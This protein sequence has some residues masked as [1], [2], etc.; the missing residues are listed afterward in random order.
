LPYLFLIIFL[1]DLVLLAVVQSL[2]GLLFIILLFPLT[3]SVYASLCFKGFRFSANE[4]IKQLAGKLYWIG[5][6]TIQATLIA[7]FNAVFGS[8]IT[9]DAILVQFDQ[10]FGFLSSIFIFLLLPLPGFLIFSFTGQ[11]QEQL[12]DLIYQ[13]IIRSGEAPEFIILTSE[14]LTKTQRYS[15][16][17]TNQLQKVQESTF[18]YIQQQYPSISHFFEPKLSYSFN[19]ENLAIFLTKKVTSVEI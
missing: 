18:H 13:E 11:D 4:D 12:Y 15:E 14:L 5:K 6:G 7:I 2:N 10:Q 8:L 19:L 17:Y 16:E 3:L 1:F 9:P